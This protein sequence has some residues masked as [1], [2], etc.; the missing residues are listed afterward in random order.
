ML[1]SDKAERL[2]AAAAILRNLS[3]EVDCQDTLISLASRINQALWTEPHNSVATLKE[4]VKVKQTLRH[5]QEV[6]ELWK[7]REALNG[8]VLLMT[9]N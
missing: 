9:T 1:T 8:V 7:I 2:L 6:R 4:I 3:A 5:M